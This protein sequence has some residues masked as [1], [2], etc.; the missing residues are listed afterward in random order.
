M[1]HMSFGQRCELTVTGQLAGSVVETLR[2]RF[3]VVSICAA[4]GTVLTVDNVDQAAVRAVMI[5][6][7]DTG[8]EVLSMTTIP[9]GAGQPR[10][11]E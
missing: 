1:G 3:T 11:V 9:S 10:A 6:L 8:H 7:W 4:E 2:S 5:M